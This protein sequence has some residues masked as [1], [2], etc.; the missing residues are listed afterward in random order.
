LLI[1][2]SRYRG[3]HSPLRCVRCFFPHRAP[4]R[5]GFGRVSLYP[6][7]PDADLFE[8][9]LKGGFVAV[10]QNHAIGKSLCVSLA[11]LRIGQNEGFDVGIVAPVGRNG[12]EQLLGI[13]ADATD[14]RLPE[15]ELL[16]MGLIFNVPFWIFYPV[17]CRHSSYGRRDEGE[18]R[19]RITR[20]GRIASSRHDKQ[21]AENALHAKTKI[22]LTLA[23]SPRGHSSDV[24]LGILT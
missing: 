5:N 23:L 20:G 3:S 14:K 7:D 18:G 13:A 8:D 11:G 9:L 1:S 2:I 21:L 4:A 10:I 6:V 19:H 17:V 12:V 24:R 15:V 22:R 16:S